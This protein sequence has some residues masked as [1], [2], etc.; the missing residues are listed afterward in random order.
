MR[1][2]LHVGPP[3]TILG[4]MN[5][6]LERRQLPPNQFWKLRNLRLK[7]EAFSRRKGMARLLAA[8][9]PA[10]SLKCADGDPASYIQ[11]PYSDTANITDYNLGTRF[12][13]FVACKVNSLGSDALIMAATRTPPL[14]PPPR[15][16]RRPHRSGST[17]SSGT[18]PTPTSTSTAPRRRRRRT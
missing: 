5:T 3:F 18:G 8:A 1:Q 9:L 11:I 14:A 10:T 13:V 4:G 17:S 16:T 15:A 7:G 6:T 12:T 2:T